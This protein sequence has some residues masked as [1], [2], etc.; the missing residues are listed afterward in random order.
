M[1]SRKVE[2]IQDIIFLYHAGLKKCKYDAE[3]KKAKKD[4]IKQL[5]K[6]GIP[7]NEINNFVGE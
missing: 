6:A 5:I 3:R 4:C 2:E 1:K 7:E